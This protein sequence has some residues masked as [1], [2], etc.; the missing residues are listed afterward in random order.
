MLQPMLQTLIMVENAFRL[1]RM[2]QFAHQADGPERSSPIGFKN[3][4]N[5]S[6]CQVPKAAAM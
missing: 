6:V 3:D 1:D 2:I 5:D 4:E